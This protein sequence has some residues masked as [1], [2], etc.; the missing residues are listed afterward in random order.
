MIRR[1]SL[2]CLAFSGLAWVACGPATAP[3][4]PT[5]IISSANTSAAPSATAREAPS[6]NA[7]SEP[8]TAPVDLACKALDDVRAE[9]TG[10]LRLLTQSKDPLAH[11]QSMSDDLLA[12]FGRCK[13]T[14]SGGAWGLGVGDLREETTVHGTTGQVLAWHA[15]AQGHTTSVVLPG[16]SPR[17]NERSFAST[18]LD[19]VSIGMQEPF[20]FDG[21]G[22]EE[23]IVV[24]WDQTHEGPRDPGGVVVTFKGGAAALYAPSQ[25]ISFFRAEDVDRDGR[26][27]LITYGPYRAHVPGRCNGTPAAAVGPALLAHSLPDGTFTMTDARALAF[28]KQACD[29]PGFAV[30]RDDDKRVDDDQTFVNLACARLWGMPDA[31]AQKL[32]DAACHPLVGDAAC[33]DSALTTCVY[34]AELKAWARAKP[35]L[36]LK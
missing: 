27:D 8:A 23:L 15:D 2:G 5:V 29:K 9:Q 12:A 4:S 17:T 21:D 19:H 26:P 16:T 36:S 25:E 31:E 14:K 34:P 33:K 10:K 7:S 6:A 13:K 24:G 1:R 3:V 20:D 30:A 18:D 22:E 28:A 11:L 35:P 32:V